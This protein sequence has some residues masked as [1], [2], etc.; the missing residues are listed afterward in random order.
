[1][2]I[3][4]LLNMSFFQVINIGPP[5]DNCVTSAE[6]I[7]TCLQ[8]CNQRHAEGKCDCADTLDD[9]RDNGTLPRC[10]VTGILCVMKVRGMSPTN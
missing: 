10:D 2:R 6:P 7:S 8:R 9:F 1:M 3:I 4:S 5:F